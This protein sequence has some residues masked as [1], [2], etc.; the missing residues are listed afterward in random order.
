MVTHQPSLL[1]ILCWFRFNKKQ[2]RTQN[3]ASP[4][5]GPKPMRPEWGG[6][7]WGSAFYLRLESQE[8]RRRG[9]L[10]LLQGRC[11]CRNGQRA[12]QRAGLRGRG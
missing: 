6:E 2:K 4:F 3:K 12:T 9:L 8:P 5:P 1:S 10:R 11:Q 7:L